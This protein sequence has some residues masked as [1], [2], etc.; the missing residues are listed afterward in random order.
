MGAIVMNYDT[1]QG[2]QPYIIDIADRK[3]D[4]WTNHRYVMRRER[5]DVHSL[6][7]VYDG[8]GILELNGNQ[9]ELHNGVLFYIPKNSQMLIRT[10]PDKLLKY[11]SIMF[12][13]DQFQ[14][15]G[16][17]QRTED[18]RLPIANIHL[19]Q[20]N[21]LLLERYFKI[22]SIWNL[23]EAGYHWYSKLELL[24][25]LDLIVNMVRENLEHFKSNQDLIKAAMAYMR[26]NLNADFD[27]VEMAKRLSISPGYFNSLFKQHTGHTPTRFMTHLRMDRAKQLLRYTRLPIGEIADEV[28]YR[29][30]YYFSRL[31]SKETG[32]SP[33]K[34]RSS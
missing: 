11:C 21:Q 22:L 20:E 33:R 2:F 32:M 5:T 29:D 26:D 23:K 10:Q 12:H 1:L 6:A 4:F 25:L 34:F 15:E 30:A 7:L 31:F 28:G 14:W 17:W 24:Q 8:E 18:E 3:A 27:R 16:R 19:F 13:Y 9:N